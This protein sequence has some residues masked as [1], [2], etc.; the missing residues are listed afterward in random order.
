VHNPLRDL[1]RII[2]TGS[3][4]KILT[5]IF[6]AAFLTLTSEPCLRRGLPEGLGKPVA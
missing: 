6:I 3:K 5:V 1:K 2:E 4:S